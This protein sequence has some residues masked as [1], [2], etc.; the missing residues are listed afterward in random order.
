MEYL[1][2]KR[3]RLKQGW[4]RKSVMGRD[5]NARWYKISLSVSE[6][7]CEVVRLLIADRN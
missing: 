1:N 4:K 2:V 7:G 6:V 5:G 3:I